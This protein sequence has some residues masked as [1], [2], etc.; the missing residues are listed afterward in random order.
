MKQQKVRLLY[1]EEVR[2]H[3]S[4]LPSINPHTRTII[5]CGF[6]NVGK[7]S[8]INRIT[9]ADVD[10]QEYACTTR[11]LFVGHTDYKGLT[12]QVVDTPGILDHALED[13]NT[14]EMQTVTALAHLRSSII[15]I[16]DI[17]ETCDHTIQEQVHFLFVD[18]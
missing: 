13:R 2:Q 4:R 11:S 14:I 10:V 15:F 17:S 5:L 16:L 7:S 12:W 3:M 8:F 1:L 6:P 9:R 18:E